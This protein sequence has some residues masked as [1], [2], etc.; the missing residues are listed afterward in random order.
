[1]TTTRTAHPAVTR[2]ERLVCDE[3]SAALACVARNSSVRTF[4]CTDAGPAGTFKAHRAQALHVAA[5][6]SAGS[7]FAIVQ[8]A[9]GGYWA[10]EWT[11]TGYGQDKTVQ[12][13]RAGRGAT[14]T[15]AVSAMLAELS[16]HNSHYFAPEEGRLGRLRRT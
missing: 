10:S 2:P 14:V 16:F 5:E 15:E 12:R 13:R 8:P 9:R 3:V 11:V 7:L 1:M 4:D 6:L